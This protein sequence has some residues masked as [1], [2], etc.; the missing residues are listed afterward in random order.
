MSNQHYI[1]VLDPSGNV[2]AVADPAQTPAGLEYSIATSNQQSA[3]EIQAPPDLMRRP[4]AEMKRFIKAQIDGGTSKPYVA[5][6]SR[7]HRQSR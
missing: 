5:R 3:H 7:S 1:V 4:H 2:L 6:F